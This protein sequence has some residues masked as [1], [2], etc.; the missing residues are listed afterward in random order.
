MIQTLNFAINSINLKRVV[1]RY[2]ERM[3][4]FW[5]LLDATA[6]ISST[7]LIVS[8]KHTTKY[9]TLFLLVVFGI[10]LHGIEKEKL[11]WHP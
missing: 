11:Y 5:S 7:N 8:F 3:S 4:S 1:K 6:E 9:C 10:W 2:P